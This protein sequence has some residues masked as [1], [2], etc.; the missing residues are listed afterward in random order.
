[1][2]SVRRHPKSPYWIL[3]FTK[4][5]GSRTTRSSKIP[6][7]A[8]TRELA[9]EQKEMALEIA[10]KIERAGR[11]AKREGMTT[12]RARAIINEVL[13]AAG[14]D[15][16]DTLS[17]R[18]FLNQWV[19]GKAKEGT[20]ERYRHVADLFMAHLGDKADAALGSVSYQQVLSWMESRRKEKIASKTMSVDLKIL[21]GAFALAR[22]LGHIDKNPVEQA[23]A[24]KQIS[25]TSSEKGT[26]TIQQ[27]ALLILSATPDWETVIYV[28]YYTG[29]R[30][31]DC[32]NLKRDQI[33]FKRNI[34]RTRQIKT[35]KLV[36]TPMHKDLRAHLEKRCRGMAA[37]ANVNPTLANR[38]TGGKTGLSSEFA[39]LM[40]KAGVDRGIIPGQGK[41]K[42]SKYSFH[43]L[44][45]SFNNDM[46][47]GG[48]EQEVRMELTGQTSVDT[49]EIYTHRGI[50]KLQA[51]ID[52]LPSVLA[53]AEELKSQSTV[54][55]AA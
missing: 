31:R 50:Q 51:A 26:F 43:S 2:A 52:V 22:R 29:G 38:K 11:Q 49:N 55:K 46:A 13:K 25:V 37:D 15:Q 17:V 12:E 3:C 4:P 20:T 19:D 48:V 27:V 8:K 14:V 42:F 28:A 1:M 54:S 5:D 53:A 21:R 30:L 24:M 9:K 10:N 18:A 33:D 39:A 41:R 16:V 6:V 34:I 32:T 44:R 40:E 45:H 47:D 36:W 23:L 35:G 7:A